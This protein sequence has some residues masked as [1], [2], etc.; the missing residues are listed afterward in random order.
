MYPSCQEGIGRDDTKG[1]ECGLT[2]KALGLLRSVELS[3][4]EQGGRCYRVI[5]V[6]E[7]GKLG[8]WKQMVFLLELIFSSE[9]ESNNFSSR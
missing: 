1:G 4:S 3:M 6:G 7:I 5:H 9:I 8:S 2:G